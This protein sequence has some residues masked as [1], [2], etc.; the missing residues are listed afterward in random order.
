[1]L[2]GRKTRADQAKDAAAG[3]LTKVRSAASDAADN[4]ADSDFAA[5]AADAA[6]AAEAALTAKAHEAAAAAEQARGRRKQ[7]AAKAHAEAAMTEAASARKDLEAKLIEQARDAAST[8]QK[9]AARTAKSPTG[10]GTRRATKAALKEAKAAAKAQKKARNSHPFRKLF[11]LALAGGGAALAAS[12]D[13][14]L[15]AM[16]AVSGATKG[17]GFA[18]DPATGPIASAPPQQQPGN[19]SGSTETAN[20]A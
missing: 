9:A 11:I 6:R 3:A 19:G 10:R 1:M 13:L 18:A 14:R 4:V 17:N 12:E 5:R 2:M 20:K 7:K 16:A 8:A 15:K